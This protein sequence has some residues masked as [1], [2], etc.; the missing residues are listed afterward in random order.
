MLGIS[1]RSALSVLD[2]FLDVDNLWLQLAL[3]TFRV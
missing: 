2:Q 1:D 3:A